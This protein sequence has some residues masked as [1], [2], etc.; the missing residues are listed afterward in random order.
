MVIKLQKILK[1]T[2][3]IR[4]FVWKIKVGMKNKVIA[5][6]IS[7][8]FAS[9]SLNRNTVLVEEILAAYDIPVRPGYEG[10]NPYWN[11][12]AVK[13]MYA[14]AFDF[15]DVEG[16]AAYR[17]TVTQDVEDDPMLW[18]FTAEAPNLSLAPMWRDIN[19]GNV[20]LKVEALDKDGDVMATAGERK[21]YRDTPFSP[22]YHS[23]VR[24]YRESAIL[25]LICIH[26]MQP[27]QN[28]KKGPF[29]DMSYQLNTY[30]AKII[31]STISSEVLLSKLCPELKEDAL[32]IAE[33]AARFLMDQSRPEGEPL[34]YFPPTYYG[35]LITSGIDRNKGKTMAMEALTAAA[36]FLDLFDVTSKQEYFDQ[37]M[38]ITETYEK[39]QAED[40]SFPI[41]MD[42][43]TG[44]PVNAVKAML[45]PMLEY[46]Q[47]LE[48]QYGIDKFNDMYRRSEYWMKNSALKTFDM[49]GQFED[50]RVEGL[51]P[52][53]NLTN[54]TAAPYASFLLGKE[55]MTPEELCDARDLIN[56][57]EDQFV[58]WASPEK[59][60]GVQHYHTPHVVEQYRYRV[61][62]DHSACNVAN[63]WLSLY[64]VTGDE[65]AF[66][67]AKALIDNITIM[68]DINT[69]MIPTYWCNFLTAEN[70]TNCTLLS[71]Q[72]LLRMD[73]ITSSNIPRSRN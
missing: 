63:A 33:N 58:Y 40:G 45:H 71:I 37:A 67:K 47:R 49:T 56:F 51:E 13:F 42:F 2:V 41:K 25:A 23:A 54:C 50:A 24:D 38:R 32:K 11:K 6:L 12:F 44:E 48:K 43:V 7:L 52:Y 5:I 61:P 73:E 55:D 30:A 72:T 17:Y 8:L 57:C 1:T 10:R 26:N 66:M 19:V 14:P 28:W 22:P 35:D 60:Y 39:I 29:P 15:K 18:S 70:W 3:N 20:I 31:G 62:I 9:C 27:I 34:E 64:E 21:F 16:A 53:Q 59:K 69:G 65:I 68:Q 36:A 46:L 4:K